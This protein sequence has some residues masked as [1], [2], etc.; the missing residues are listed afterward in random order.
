MES[1]KQKQTSVYLARQKSGRLDFFLTSLTLEGE[2][3]SVT[4]GPSVG[5]D[6]SLIHIALNIPNFQKRGNSF[7]KFNNNLLSDMD[8]VI[9]VKNVIQNTIAENSYS[10]KS[11][12]W[13]FVKC[14]IRSESMM[15]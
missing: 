15:Y 5:T 7:W 9:L 2:I 6:H 4:I 14:R 12:L 3:E 13:E 1:T 11:L 8:Y 10:D